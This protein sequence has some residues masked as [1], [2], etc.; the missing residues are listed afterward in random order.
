MKSEPQ[1]KLSVGSASE[2]E[3]L[4]AEIH[5]PKKFGLIVSQEKG[6]GD[7]EMSMH[8]FS[9]KAEDNFTYCRNI[10]REKIPL[11]VLNQSIQQAVSE[12]RRLAR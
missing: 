5:F 2:Y 8:S 9:R 11:D 7:F 6:E 10:D 3:E 4:I 12:L 1:Y